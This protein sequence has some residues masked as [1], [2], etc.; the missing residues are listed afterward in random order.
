MRILF[1]LFRILNPQFS[2]NPKY[3]CR[4]DIV[5]GAEGVD[6][7]AGLFGYAD[8]GV[9]VLNSVGEAVGI[10]TFLNGAECGGGGGVF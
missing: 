7:G 10:L 9:A 1:P 8:E 4:S 2:S 5:E 3:R 6:G